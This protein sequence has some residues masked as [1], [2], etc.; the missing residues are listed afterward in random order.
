MKKRI[1]IV[2]GMARSGKDTFAKFLDEFVP[3]FKYS[4]IDK[5]KHIAAQC[6]WTGGKTEKDRKFLSDL[7]MLT[8]EYSDMSFVD[9]SIM[10]A[11]FSVDDCYSVMLIDIREPEEIEKAK[12]ILNAE[13]IFIDNPR[14]EQ[15]TSNFGDAHVGEYQYDY[16]LYN[17]GTLEDFRE[18]AKWFAEDIILNKEKETKNHE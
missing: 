16:V 13:T 11:R 15:I 5:V 8:T 10:V 2:N 6:G 12:R 17:S 7:K 18:V 3:V 1:F 9:I 4:S 14:V